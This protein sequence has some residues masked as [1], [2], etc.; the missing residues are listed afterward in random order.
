MPAQVAG[1]AA[2]RQGLDDGW[3]DV[4]YMR[5]TYNKRRRFLV[6]AM[7]DL[8]LTCREPE[9]AFYVFPSIQRTGLSSEAF[10]EKL[11]DEENVAA[12]PGSAFGPA[13]EGF[14][15][16]CYASSMEHLEKALERIAEL[17]RRMG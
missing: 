3:Q 7:N 5:D 9:G 2:L 14:M 11:L 16:C 13:G 10:C 4:I 6:D 17:L 1:V 12:I 8:G 15:R